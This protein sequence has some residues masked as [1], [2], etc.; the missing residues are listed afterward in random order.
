MTLRVIPDATS[1]IS[2]LPPKVI[3]EAEYRP[4][5]SPSQSLT[6]ISAPQPLLVPFAII[7]MFFWC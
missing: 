3:E 4:P 7:V 5:Q 6:I 2:K 1:S